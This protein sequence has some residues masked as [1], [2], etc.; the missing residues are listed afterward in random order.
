M[1]IMSVILSLAAIACQGSA[2]SEAPQTTVVTTAE[3][4]PA[5]DGA[6]EGITLKLSLIHI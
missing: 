1:R 2:P 3:A 6:I 5:D 4:P